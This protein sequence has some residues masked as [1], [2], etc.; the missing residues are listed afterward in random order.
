M[1]LARLG[2]AAQAIA[3]KLVATQIRNNSTW[4]DLVKCLAWPFTITKHL[5]PT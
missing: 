5:A 1:P 2:V 4:V 3:Y